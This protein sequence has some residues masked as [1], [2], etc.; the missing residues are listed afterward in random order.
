MTKYL[1]AGAGAFGREVAAW[2][3]RYTKCKPSA[4]RFLDDTKEVNTM[5]AGRWL[6]EGPIEAETAGWNVV[7]AVGDPVGRRAVVDRI[8]ARP[9]R[10][11]A[12]PYGT[13]AATA[14]FGIGI[15]MCPG[16]VISA[17]AF[18]GSFTHIN[19]GAA[20][21]HDV[22]VGAYCTLSSHV[23]LCGGVGL[24]DGVF[25][26]SGA[27]ILPGVT[28]GAGARIGA[29]SVVTRDVGHGEEVFGNPA[30]RLK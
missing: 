25:V 26:G 9:T 15:V 4:I 19:I 30:R 28:I 3:E 1:I 24:G 13:V 17:G 16:S 23:D 5:V 20:V 8:S 18:V 12:L 7:V 10:F 27:R 14:D 22:E 11:V 21:G 29:G 6:V 2:I